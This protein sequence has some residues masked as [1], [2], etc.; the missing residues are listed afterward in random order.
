MVSMV[1]ASSNDCAGKVFE[2]LDAGTQK[3]MEAQSVHWQAWCA[4]GEPADQ[5][6]RHPISCRESSGTAYCAAVQRLSAGHGCPIRAC[7]RPWTGQTTYLKALNPH[8]AAQEAPLGSGKLSGCTP[9]E[10]SN[11]ASS[12]LCSTVLHDFHR[13]VR[14]KTI[15]GCK[16]HLEAQVDRIPR[17][18]VRERVASSLSLLL[19]ERYICTAPGHSS[20]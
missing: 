18:V 12:L 5:S 7:R 13:L 10:Q 3:L 6:G 11:S 20:K 16:H 15:S 1:Q 17:A 19:E 14:S 4:P 2:V 8:P 9:A